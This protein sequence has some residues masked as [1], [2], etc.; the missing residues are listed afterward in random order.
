MS[1]PRPPVRLLGMEAIINHPAGSSTRPTNT[2]IWTARILGALLILFLLVDGAGKVMRL[3]P[4]VE[5]T[6]KVGYS[7]GCLVPLGLVLLASTILYAIRRTAVLGAILLTGYLGGATATHVRMG[8]P[9][10]FPVVFGVLVW[11]CLYLR[12]DHLRLL[13]PFDRRMNERRDSHV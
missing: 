1:T 7:A 2:K 12:D 4:Y 3:A 11:A 5:G 10:F 8:Q 13:L 6:A 9:F